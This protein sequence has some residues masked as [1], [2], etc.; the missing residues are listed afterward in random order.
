MGPEAT[1]QTQSQPSP[2]VYPGTGKEHMNIELAIAK[3]LI[4]EMEDTPDKSP[5]ARKHYRRIA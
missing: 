4:T 1:T 3:K 5:S 2:A